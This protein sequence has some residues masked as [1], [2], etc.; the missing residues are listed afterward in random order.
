M[1]SY[2]AFKSKLADKHLK[3]RYESAIQCYLTKELNNS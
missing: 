3:S 1:Q 2:L